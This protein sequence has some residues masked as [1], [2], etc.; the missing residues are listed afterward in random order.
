MEALPRRE[1]DLMAWIRDLHAL[2]QADSNGGE[3]GMSTAARLLGHMVSGFG[4]EGGYLALPPDGEDGSALVVAATLNLPEVK[5]G[6]PLNLVCGLVQDWSQRDG[7]D[8]IGAGPDLL[9]D[10]DYGV[11]L[12]LITNDRLLGALRLHR[13]SG[14]APFDAA[15]WER[16]SVMVA[17]LALVID[18]R[19]LHVEQRQR[20][21]ELS[22]VNT[23]LENAHSQLLQADKMASIGQ[24]AAGVAHE[25]NNPIGYVNSNLGSLESYIDDVFRV[26]DA[27]GAVDAAALNPAV[28]APVRQLRQ[29]LDIDFL[30]E[31]ARALMSETR[32]GLSRVKKIV[33]DLKTFSHPGG[34]GEWAYAD[35]QACLDSTLSICNNELKYKARVVKHYGALPEVRCLR[36]QLN[37]VFLNLLV[38]AC[39]AIEAQGTITVTTRLQGTEAVVEI[40][41][42]G[43]GIL[44]GHLSKIFDPF[45]TTKPVGQG[46][47]LGLSLSYSMVQ[48]HGGRIEV[49]SQPGVGTT[50]RVILPVHGP[51][52]VS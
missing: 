4:A 47:G 15:D 39:H 48:K 12:P 45:F 44:P 1:I 52:A 11:F 30:K 42:T 50:F 34:E 14:R 49:D 20:I 24:L 36:S 9:R 29:E 18:N 8:S 2:S 46:T 38:N 40:S 7:D 6:T 17:L 21:Q 25:I 3:V 28:F 10:D 26:V 23:Q 32:E 22:R 13:R 41:D 43:C 16:G 37:Q 35:L 27:Y 51:V 31:D 5:L 19:R 33:H